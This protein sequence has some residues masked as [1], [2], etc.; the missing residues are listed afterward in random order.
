[1]NA[2]ALA[3]GAPDVAA[4][5]EEHV[6]T[7]VLSFLVAAGCVV[8]VLP[9]GVRYRDASPALARLGVDVD[10]WPVPPAGLTVVEERTI[11]VRS[12]DRMV[13]VHEVGHLVDLALGGGIYC[14]SQR[15]DV[16]AAFSAARQFVTPYAATGLDE[17]FAEGF[18]AAC[19]ANDDA[20]P[21]P[22]VSP[23][24]LRDVDTVLASIMERIAADPAAFVGGESR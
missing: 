20:S 23:E 14:S 24:R 21:W 5:L 9:D 3:P 4:I 16:R 1:M 6:P 10:A 13:V 15:D 22:R 8:R 7:P 18:R 17:Y 19:N 2:S 12:A 11:Y